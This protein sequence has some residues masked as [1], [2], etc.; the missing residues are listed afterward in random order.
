[1]DEEDRVGVGTRGI[2]RGQGAAAPE[3]HRLSRRSEAPSEAGIARTIWSGSRTFSSRALSITRFGCRSAARSTG[4]LKP[5]LHADRYHCDSAQAAVRGSLV[6]N[7]DRMAAPA[8]YGSVCLSIYAQ[9]SAALAR[10]EVLAQL[11]HAP[12]RSSLCRACPTSHVEA[13]PSAWLP[14]RPVTKPRQPR[15]AMALRSRLPTAKAPSG[16][17][18]TDVSRTSHPPSGHIRAE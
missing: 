9:T 18:A 11:G 5:P 16:G 7:T 6:Q 4:V 2:P 8:T 1:L 3:V 12:K 17:R 15:H 10:K 13:A 14:R